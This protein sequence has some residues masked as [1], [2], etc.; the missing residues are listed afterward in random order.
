MNKAEDLVQKLQT[1]PAND[2]ITSAL[3]KARNMGEPF[4][5]VI[6]RELTKYDEPLAQIRQQMADC[7]AQL[8]QVDRAWTDYK[9]MADATTDERS[10]SLRGL[11]NSV[12]GLIESRSELSVGMNFFS[13][14]TDYLRT[15]SQQV[16]DFLAV[17]RA[18]REHILSNIHLQTGKLPAPF[19]EGGKRADGR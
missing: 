10:Q 4:D 19:M 15:L 7:R 5:H 11:E 17:R 12:N 16:T 1:A 2:N 9:T 13:L 3:M 6:D 18:E 14:L 8:K